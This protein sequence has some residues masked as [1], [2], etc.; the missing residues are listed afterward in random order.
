MFL[1]V[2]TP[3]AFGAIVN[4]AIHAIPKIRYDYSYRVSDS[5]VFRYYGGI[6]IRRPTM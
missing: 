1:P 4:A 5:S 3:S 6:I 2:A